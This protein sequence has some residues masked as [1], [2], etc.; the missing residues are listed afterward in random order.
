MASLRR[1][2]SEP[3]SNISAG[4]QLMTKVVLRIRDIQQ[5]SLLQRGMLTRNTKP[6]VF[7]GL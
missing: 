4:S 6:Y 5:H 1:L 2:A 3:F 7:F